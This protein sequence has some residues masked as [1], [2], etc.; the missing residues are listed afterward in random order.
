MRGLII[1]IVTLVAL[2][3]P[4]WAQRV[5]NGKTM[6]VSRT[7]PFTTCV[8]STAAIGRKENLITISFRP[9]KPSAIALP[10]GWPAGS[11]QAPS[12]KEP[13]CRESFI[14]P[15]EPPASAES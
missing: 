15:T 4:A 7:L 5:S 11:S 14:I 9:P 13:F 8:P 10:Y 2:V 6:A 1:T 12:R 3:L